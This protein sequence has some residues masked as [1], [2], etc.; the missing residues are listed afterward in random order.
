M[1]LLIM[2]R[3]T[4][5]VEYSGGDIRIINKALVPLYLRRTGNVQ[6]WLESR[7]I[8]QHRAN[9]RL[10]KKALRLRERDDIGTVLAV[11]AATITDS[12]WVKPPESCL[13]YSDIRFD[14]DYF[15]TLALRG[16]YDSFNRAANSNSS[17][18]PELTN[19]GS[20]EKCW[21]LIDG[22]WWM[23]K[24]AN[25]D[26]LFSEL[27]IYR[28][29]SKLGFN[30]A[31][32]R[33]G[34]GVIKTRD[35]TCHASVNF[36][37]AF[38]IMD[39]NEDYAETFSALKELEPL[40]TGDYVRMLFLDTICANPDRHTFNFGVLR[41]ADNGK[42][43]G[44]APNFDNNVALISR[45]YPRNISRKNDLLVRLFN[46]F[47]EAVPEAKEYIPELREEMLI[48]V[49]KELGMR[50]RGRE[51]TEF[52]MNGYRMIER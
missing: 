33:R 43:L 12:Y 8:D 34:R 31:E 45:G 4:V 51:V 20:F 32:Y 42:V 28:L 18:T 48:E 19:I 23:Y 21:R 47:T 37:P 50:V 1:E 41:N 38:S 46:E 49:L 25:H 27:F 2:S 39:G 3:D 10:L 5:T 11:N 6:G 22:E 7:A 29:G 16:D 9:S 17:K 24:R 26:E 14:N 30:M 36:E 44:M 13:S 15:S 35:F 52:I 40:C